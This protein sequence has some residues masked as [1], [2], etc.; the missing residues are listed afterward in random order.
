MFYWLGRGFDAIGAIGFAA[1]VAI[2]AV[3]TGSPLWLPIALAIPAIGVAL[4]G[5]WDWKRRVARASV[6]APVSNPTQN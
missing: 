2:A 4:F 6:A 3:E 1:L 5:R